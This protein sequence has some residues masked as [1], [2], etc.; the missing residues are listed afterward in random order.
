MLSL[1]DCFTQEL[2]S[3]LGAFRSIKLQDPND[4]FSIAV[5]VSR[6]F[7]FCFV[8]PSFPSLLLLDQPSV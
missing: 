6:S 2:Q 1:F 4:R 5:K 8:D 3:D 7:F